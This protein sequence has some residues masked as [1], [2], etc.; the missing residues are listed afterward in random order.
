[1]GTVSKQVPTRDPIHGTDT[2][3]TRSVNITD[4][5]TSKSKDLFC[6]ELCT[7]TSSYSSHDI[8]FSPYDTFVKR[9]EE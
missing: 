7:V 4:G 5:S 2:L 8:R 3:L 9:P 1:M 6:L